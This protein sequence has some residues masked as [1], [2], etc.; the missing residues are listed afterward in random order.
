MV[1]KVQVAEKVI[2]HGLQSW[3]QSL[4]DSLSAWQSAINFMNLDATIGVKITPGK[5]QYTFTGQ[6]AEAARSFVTEIVEKFPMGKFEREQK[7]IEDCL[8][9]YKKL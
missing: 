2:L 5:Y 8:D 6:D 4:T 7:M 9:K 3:G 1:N